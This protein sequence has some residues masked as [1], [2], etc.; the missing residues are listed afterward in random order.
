MHDYLT[1]VEDFSGF[2]SLDYRCIEIENSVNSIKYQGSV[3]IIV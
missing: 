3:C 2:K 1:Q